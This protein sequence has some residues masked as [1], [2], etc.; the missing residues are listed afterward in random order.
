G[1]LV[2]SL[3]PELEFII[4]KQTPVAALL[5]TDAESRFHMVFRSFLSVCAYKEHP[6]AVFLDDLQWL[7]AA[8]LKLLEH[9]MTHPDVRHLLLI[10]AF[11]D[12]EVVA[13]HPLMRTLDAIRAT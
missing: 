12:N 8:A 1:Q 5:A 11:R 10:G 6:L 2:V 3:I 7:D 9:L 4:G 13:S